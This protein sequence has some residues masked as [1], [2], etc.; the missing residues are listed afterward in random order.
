MAKV[1]EICF[2]IVQKTFEFFQNITKVTIFWPKIIENFKDSCP[3]KVKNSQIL[4]RNW[5]KIKQSM[6]QWPKSGCM[7]QNRQKNPK[8]SAQ[9]NKNFKNLGQK[10]PKIEK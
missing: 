9:K 1:K 3:K 4:Q 8:I 6:E 2:K 5:P 7:A 10:R